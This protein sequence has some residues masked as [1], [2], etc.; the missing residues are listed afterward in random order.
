MNLPDPIKERNEKK[1]S[2]KDFIVFYNENLPERFPQAS[3]PFLREFK[4]T[5]PKLF[6]EDNTWSLDQHRKKFMDWLPQ[7]IKTLH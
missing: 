7:H 6:G 1:L 4:K 2:S 3:P 5:H